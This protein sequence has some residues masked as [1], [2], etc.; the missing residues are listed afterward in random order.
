MAN[1]LNTTVAANYNSVFNSNL[2]NNGLSQGLGGRTVI[3]TIVKDSGDMTE[4][5]LVAVLRAL[6]VAGG[7]GKGTDSDG[8]DA[9][10]IAGVYWDGSNDPAYVALQGTGTVNT[11]PVTGYTVAEVVVFA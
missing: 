4:A 9:F 11:A 1:L 8:P 2:L 6:T 5:Q 3:A 10:T 7:D